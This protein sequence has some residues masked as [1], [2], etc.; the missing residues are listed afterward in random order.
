MLAPVIIL[1]LLTVLVAT[2]PDRQDGGAPL[3]QN[4][5][6]PKNP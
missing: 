1:S 2:E 3:P 4:P 5:S 6:Q